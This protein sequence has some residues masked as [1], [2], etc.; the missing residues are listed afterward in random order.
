MKL[1]NR[2]LHNPVLTIRLS[3]LYLV[4]VT[5]LIL[6]KGTA[7]SQDPVRIMPLGNSITYGNY[8]P[9]PRPEGLI[10]GYRQ[11]LWL[12]LTNAGYQV[13]FVGSRTTGADAV[14]AFDPHNEGYP[15]W[16]DDQIEVN[17][18]DWLW[19][20]EADVIIL[21]IGT[22][23]LDP[24]PSDV[25]AILDEI[26]RYE[27]NHGHHIKV[28]LAKII[29]RITYSQLTTQF[30][31]NIEKMALDRVKNNGDD[32]VVIDME[33]ETE[34]DYRIN[35]AGGEM[36]DNLH[37]YVGGHEKM[38]VR[39]FEVLQEVLPRPD[40]KPYIISEPNP[41]T[42]S[43]D[44]FEYQVEADG[45]PSPQFS[46]LESPS[47]MAINGNRDITWTPSSSGTYMVRILAE[48]AI[49]KDTQQFE[50]IVRDAN[51][52]VKEG[53]VALYEFTEGEGNLVHDVSGVGMPDNLYINYEGNV[54]WDPEQGLEIT[55]ESILL[56]SDMNRKIID[57]C[58]ESGA[59]TIETWLR[60]GNMEQ[61]GPAHIVQISDPLNAGISL[62]QENEFTD[63]VRYYFTAAGTPV[64]NS[65]PYISSIAIQH[66]VYTRD[67][68]GTE[69]IYINGQ[70]AGSGTK[71]G[72][73]SG[74][75]EHTFKLSLCNSLG[76]EHPWTGKLFLTAIYNRI[77]SQAEVTQNYDAGFGD[78][79]I[80]MI[81][82][83]QPGSLGSTP[84][85]TVAVKLTWNDLS[86]D[87]TGFVIER[88]V[89][90]GLFQYVSSVPDN[91]TQYV[92]AG[93]TA[94]TV[95]YYRIKALNDFMESEYSNV[96]SVR[97]FS[98]DFL[99]H[100]SRN[101]SATQ[102]S[103]VYGG[104]ASLGVD[105]NTDG[106]YSNGSVTHTAYELNAWWEVDLQTVYN[107][108]YIEVWNRTDNCCKDRM[109]RFNLFVSEEPFESYDFQST[110]EQ[111]GVWT[112]YE[113]LYPEPMVLFNVARKGRYIRLQLSD[114]QEICLAELVAMGND[115]LD[116][117]LFITTPDTDATQGV[118]YRYDFDASDPDADSLVFTFLQKPDW[119]IFDPV[120]KTLIGIP[121]QADTGD[122][123]VI[124][125]VYDGLNNVEQSF[126]IQVANV[127]DP[128]V[129]TS[130]PVL[131]VNK[132]E[133]YN[134][135]LEFN[136][137]DNDP[138]TVEISQKPDW[139][140]FEESILTL[141][142]IPDN[143]D[144][145]V[146]DITIL[147]SDG[148]ETV[149]QSFQVT[150]ID[151]NHPPV[152]TSEPD[153]V[154]D[155]GALFSYQI[156]V[157]DPDQDVL[158]FSFPGKPDW[159]TFNPI[160]HT[161][162]GIPEQED[163]GIST[164]SIHISDGTA[165]IVQD[166][167]L[168]VIDVN[169]PPE[170][171][172][173][174]VLTVYE[175][176]VYSYSFLAQDVDGDE[177]TF[178][179]VVLPDWLTFDVTLRNLTGTPTNEHVGIHDVKIRVSDGKGHVDHSFQITVLNVN[180]PPVLTSVPNDTIIFSGEQ[181]Q[182]QIT[183]VDVDAGDL[184]TI[185]AVDLPGWLTLTPASHEAMLRGTPSISDVGSYTIGIRVSDGTVEVGHNFSLEVQDPS[186]VEPL[187]VP[188][189]RIYPIPAGE[190]VYFEFG[191][192]GSAIVK[193]YD[194]TGTVLKEVNVNTH[195][196]LKLDISDL[197]ANLYFYKVIVNE[198]TCV[199]KLIKE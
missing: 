105:G 107:I 71:T 176:S 65:S 118:E 189:T 34:I 27:S 37:P 7:Y 157:S 11:A 126:T 51:N 14:P 117:P 175:D 53:L 185:S 199:G 20:N 32:I 109:A 108:N 112:V 45:D 96:T 91:N 48:N 13:D 41:F 161:L 16:R 154:V 190:I 134:Y 174:P 35:T 75:N 186:G 125:N 84:L 56:P 111:P 23:G 181:Y 72:D 86:D 19:N 168:T 128:P 46:L 188:V 88:R 162:S 9:E 39:W 80:T 73:F 21:H 85:S 183:A 78:Q 87:E 152:I 31:Q 40:Q 17:V 104:E 193:L 63:S 115:H 149:E 132:N 151:Y 191:L 59:I 150:V 69:K 196:T 135:T 133:A 77:L 155:Q 153:T 165:E 55:R 120:S 58:M 90:S 182:F 94:N 167:Q 179:A 129:I 101:K 12:L 170:I 76:F 74:W 50:I 28:I 43:G 33:F 178:T 4:L 116:P 99:T 79:P 102:S 138:L 141:T 198:I 68:D 159:L 158:N 8:H 67:A 93:L 163:V 136:D 147:I 166:F 156:I 124:I 119:L 110:L 146:H 123:E 139:M 18:Y 36:N 100:I 66:L 194:I 24:D 184:L 169:D 44:L 164:V 29:N 127:N 197:K 187:G 122:Q 142:G 62:S 22:N 83:E 103:T 95:Y 171:L 61:G 52:R 177:L 60:T 144:V 26:D 15:G 160:T 192:K 57:S 148:T 30:N 2:I 121:A 173:S 81:P 10:T 114:S 54:I 97:T 82:P 49:G 47:G 180:D 195:E 6:L 130:D 89:E 145:G 172:S 131:E 98:D 1:S 70:E 140:Q 92:D 113:D 143:G 137:P 42:F 25:E 3:A 38:A 5:V 106:R 64:L